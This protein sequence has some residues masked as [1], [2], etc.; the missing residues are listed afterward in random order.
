[1]VD[2]PEAPAVRRSRFLYLYVVYVFSMLVSSCKN[3]YLLKKEA[4]AATETE[5]KKEKG[6]QE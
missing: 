1:M 2:R 3:G 4:N 6:D 5:E